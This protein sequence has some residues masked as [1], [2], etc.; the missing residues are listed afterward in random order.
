[1]SKQQNSEKPSI[2]T[3]AG[4]FVRRTHTAKSL[5]V[6]ESPI[7]MYLVSKLSASPIP[8]GF[9]LDRRSLNAAFGQVGAFL[10]AIFEEAEASVSGLEKLAKKG[11]DDA[12]KQLTQVKKA[13]E[14]MY[15]FRKSGKYDDIKARIRDAK[16]SGVT[17][18]KQQEKPKATGGSKPATERKPSRKERK[19]KREAAALKEQQ[20]EQPAEQPQ[21]ETQQPAA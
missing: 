10:E 12:A 4:L 17:A 13:L 21:A 7:A 14:E 15:N 1:M 11:D 9:K 18:T 16:A 8:D 20:V 5:T 2:N 6:R 19:V 3:N